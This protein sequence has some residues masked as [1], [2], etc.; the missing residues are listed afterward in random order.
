MINEKEEFDAYTGTV[1]YTAKGK[2][3][4][5]YLGRFTFDSI[6]DGDGA[7]PRPDRYRTGI[8]VAF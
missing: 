6:L 3:D 7:C 2:Q 5:A 1:A 8:S 4:T